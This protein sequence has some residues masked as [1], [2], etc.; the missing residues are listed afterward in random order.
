M[1]LSAPEGD[2]VSDQLED[3]CAFFVVLLVDCVDIG[4]SFLEGSVCY[5][6][7]GFAVSADLPE[8]D[9]HVQV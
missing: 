2:V 6:Q 1:L 5:V 3:H 7:G 4:D 9:G 8:E